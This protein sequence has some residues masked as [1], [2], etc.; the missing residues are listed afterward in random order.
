MKPEQIAFIHDAKTDLQK[1]ELFEKVKRGDIRVLM[2]SSQKMG[3]GMNVQNK[4]VALHHLDAPWRPS[5]LEQR[6]GRII[7]QGNEFYKENPNGFEVKINRY[8]TKQTLDSRMWQTI[9]SKANFIEQV[10]KGTG[11]REVE[12]VAGEAANAAEMKAASSGDPRI[13]QEIDLRKRIKEMEDDKRN[14]DR[15]VHRTKGIIRQTEADV[16]FYQRKVDALSI[17]AKIQQ[18]ERFIYKHEGKTVHQDDKGARDAIAKIFEKGIGNVLVKGKELV[19]GDLNGFKIVASPS[20]LLGYVNIEIVG[21]G[22]P[23]QVTNF[24]LNEGSSVGLVQKLLNQIRSI[25]EDLAQYQKALKESQDQLPILR[26]K[27]EN[28]VW[29]KTE[30]LT[31]LKAEHGALIDELKPKKSNDQQGNTQNNQ[32]QN[33]KFSR[34]E[35]QTITGTKVNQIEQ[36]LNDRFGND[37]V[38][39]LKDNGKLEIVQNIENETAEGFAENGKVTLIADNIHPENIIP[40]FL[41]EVGGHLGFQGM[42]TENAYKNLMADF[43]RLV[44]NGDKIALEAKALADREGNAQAKLDEYL[45]YLVTRAAQAETS[46]KLAPVKR[47]VNRIVSAVKAWV[48]NK[49]GVDLKITPND[50]L[51]LSERMVSNVAQST[52]VQNTERRYSTASNPSNQ[53]H[54]AQRDLFNR[55]SQAAIAGLEKSKTLSART[56]RLFNTMMHKALTDETGEFKKTFDL[57]QDKINHVTFASSKSMDVAPNILT[58]LETWGDFAAEGKRVG[59]KLIGR[60]AKVDQDLEKVGKLFFENTLSNQAKVHTDSELRTLGYDQDQ[61]KL[62]REARAAIDT[63]LDTFSKT[64]VSKIFQH[65]GGTSKEVLELLGQDLDLNQHV[66]EVK[67]K[68]AAIVQNDPTKQAAADL[69]IEHIDKVLDKLQ[70]LKDTGY[71]PLM[72]FG[73]YVV[74]VVDPAS[75]KVAYRQHFESES[76]RN[77][78]FNNFDQSK[79]PVGYQLEKTQVNEL[80]Y[81]LF[82]GVSPETV[83]LFAKESGLPI[84]DSETAFIKHA[85]RDNHALKRLLKRQGIDGFDTDFKRVLASFVLSNSRYSANQTYNGIIDESVTEISNP[86][87]QEDAVRLRDYALDTQEELAGLK[88]FSFVWYMGFSVMFGVVNMTQPLIQTLPYLLQYSTNKT[89][90]G[91]AFLKAVQTWRKG[92]AAIPNEYKA[93]Y[94]RAKSHGHLDPQNTWMLQGQERGKSGLGASTWQLIS[95]ASGFFAQASETINRRT[96]LFAALDVAKELGQTKLEQLGFKDEYDFAVRTIQETQG[97][98]NKGNRPRLARGNVG[99]MLMMYKQFM[100][101]YIEQMVR[102][103]KRGLYGGADDE[104]K[105]RMAKL[106]GF[107][108]SRPLLIMMGLLMS[109]SGATG[110]PFVRDL[111]DVVETTG[112]MVGKPFNTEREVQIALNNALGDTLGT[113]ANTA[114]MDGVFNLNPVM[115][116]KGRMGMGDLVPASGYFS[117]LT[118]DYQKTNEGNQTFGAM[119]GL[120]D[121]ISESMAFAQKGDYGQSAIQL[122]PKAAT[123]FGQGAIAAATG[124][125]RNM[126][127]GVKTNDASVLDGVV[128]MLDAQP[129]GIAKEGRIRGLE[130]KDTAALSSVNKVWRSRYMDALGSDDQNAVKDLKTEIKEYNADNPRYPITFNQKRAETQYKKDNQSWQEKRKQ[131]KGLEWMDEENPYI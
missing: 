125:Y 70:H 36:V 128:K 14:F 77:L 68:I 29:N 51:A 78:F 47:L 97:I 43:N 40:V 37:V 11:S 101:A 24:S 84:G 107:G 46:G 19:L 90:V 96:T 88:N 20:A 118:S 41:H 15:G 2:G 123:S 105:R 50:I 113:A 83:A 116:V 30:Q 53:P 67:K 130:M 21:N 94:E 117:P 27:V 112:G 129:S 12:D 114:L 6:E 82:Q 28:S 122:L 3:A 64:T 39:Q 35:K 9:E 119:G 22:D 42:L 99:S 89:V 33:K 18:P 81:K 26:S 8:A 45:P 57:I 86:Q 10:R 126:K 17:D 98:Y 32:E 104:F 76:E 7:R 120:V 55:A 1:Q 108:I 61:I 115:D 124:D 110:L 73:K 52:K 63:S 74:R 106:V 5:D 25:P 13:L 56:T 103:Q 23:I 31:S 92:T 75:K 49:L 91:S 109:F 65:M 102:M 72:R 95:H 127:T 4:L 100:I 66:D 85:I 131:K 111:L 34:N 71:T 79:I 38:Q 16:N 59:Q 44:Q 93:Y 121:K 54:S 69:A 58:Q 48:R 80:E 87:Y 60:K 62:Y